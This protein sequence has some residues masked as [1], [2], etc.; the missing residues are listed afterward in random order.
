VDSIWGYEQEKMKCR[1]G[2]S[3]FWVSWEGKMSACGIMDF[4]IV[5][6][7]FE[8]DFAT[9]WGKLT[10]AVR[11]KTVLKECVG[12]P[13]KEICHPCAA[14]VCTETGDVN[15]KAPYLCEMADASLACWKKM[16]KKGCVED[17][18]KEN[19]K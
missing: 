15:K 11:T 5:Q 6:Y 12:C 14:I 3:T 1:A 10:E 8:T 16:M 2:R 7:P 17:E 19:H 18:K 13:K 4:P 9:C